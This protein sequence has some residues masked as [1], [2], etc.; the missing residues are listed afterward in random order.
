MFWKKIEFTALVAWKRTYGLNKNITITTLAHTISFFALIAALTAISGLFIRGAL[1]AL[2]FFFI[3]Y[4]VISIFVYLYKK[5]QYG[6]FTRII[7]RFWKRALWLFWLLELFLF[8]IYL[9]LAVIS[10]QEVAYMLDNHQLVIDPTTNLKAFFLNTLN[11]L[12]I[13]LIFNIQLLLHKYN[14]WKQA[15]NVVVAALLLRAVTEDFL[16]FYAINN[17]YSGYAWTRVPA[18]ASTK[19]GV[20]YRAA[21][22]G[23]WEQETAELKTRTAVHYTYM[24]IF[25]KLWHTV[26]I[27]IAFVFLDN[28]ANRTNG[29]SFN[30]LAANL[31][32]FYFLMF[33]NYILK[34][35]M[36]KQYLGYLGTYAFYWF[37]VNH[38]TYDLTYAYYLF[39]LKYLTFVCADLM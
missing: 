10:P 36:A 8:G 23:V 20:A 24:L 17:F 7:Q 12:F 25:L 28:V 38:N 27:F 5:S 13:I 22:L 39:N 3:A 16:Q 18:D 34:V 9:F 4:W 1:F 32:N 30:M 6:V 31:Q 29:G 14:A 21:E 35:S 26:F 33:F 19:D 37:F 15:L 2:S 11:A